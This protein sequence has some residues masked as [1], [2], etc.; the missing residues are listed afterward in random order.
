[1]PQLYGWTSCGQD[2]SC[3]LDAPNGT[4]TAGGGSGWAF[5]PYI[6][7]PAA[8]I[9]QYARLGRFDV[10]L[11]LTRDV[12]SA[13]DQANVSESALVFVNAFAREG[14]D[15][16]NLT[17]FGDGDAIIE[18]VAA[19]NNDTVVVIHS[20]A[21]VLMP[22]IDHPNITAVAYAYYPGQESG[23]SLPKL[24]WGETNPSGKLPFVVARN[25]SDYLPNSIVTDHVPE[26]QSN[27]TDT[28]FV[29]Y[30]WLAHKNTTPLFGFGLGLS[31]TT[32]DFSS[33]TL[34]ESH[35]KD[36]TTVQPTNEQWDNSRG[37]ATQSLYD[38][39]LVGHID[40][41]NTGDCYG[42]E[43]AQ[44]YIEVSGCGPWDRSLGYFVEHHTCLTLAFSF[45]SPSSLSPLASRRVLCA[46]SR[47]WASRPARRS[48]PRSASHA[49]T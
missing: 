36:S 11:A 14:L 3:K 49:K 15:R 31:Y 13:A 6:I 37:R 26:P 22:W 21:A 28:L 30:K 16:Q 45:R 47:S 9:Q 35:D 24:L 38:A 12:E 2:G 29:D 41:T 40:V 27:F 46:V 1:M 34:E 7:D 8:A 42:K 10:N 17:L 33:L 39:L 19:R 4:L 18:A 20:S 32:F 23:S 48:A 5:P 44:L 25:E 43:V